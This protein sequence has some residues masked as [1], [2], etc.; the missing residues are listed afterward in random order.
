M[1][2]TDSHILYWRYE[3]EGSHPKLQKGWIFL[4]ILDWQ[5]DHRTQMDV[6]GTARIFCKRSRNF[7][8]LPQ[9]TTTNTTKLTNY[10]NPGCWKVRVLKKYLRIA[11]EKILNPATLSPNQIHTLVIRA[12]TQSIPTAFLL[13]HDGRLHIYLQAVKF[14]L[15]MGLP[16]TPWDDLI[17][18]QKGDLHCNQAVIIKWKVG[19]FCQLNQQLLVPTAM[20]IETTLAAQPKLE[21]LGPYAQAE[22]DTGLI[23]VHQT[24]Y[25]SPHYVSLFLAEP[26]TPW[27]AWEWDQGK[28]AKIAFMLLLRCW[29]SYWL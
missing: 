17:F 12:C 29:T 8:V 28:I 20:T 1:S 7:P 6:E 5:H 15:R 24:S 2:L 13:M 16:V 10:A 3:A 9:T 19:Y 11:Q 25:M 27:A 23:K 26:L 21:L 18:A 4:D 14:H 22:G